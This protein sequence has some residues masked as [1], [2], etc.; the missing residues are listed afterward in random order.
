MGMHHDG[1]RWVKRG[2]RSGS[3]EPEESTEAVDAFLE[4]IEA[5]CRKHNMSIGHED[6]GGSFIITTP[7]DEEHIGWLNE[8][9]WEVVE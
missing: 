5:V 8:A 7:V 1:R 3:Y 9:S 6:T 2:S 4:E